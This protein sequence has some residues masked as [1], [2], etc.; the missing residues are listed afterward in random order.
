MKRKI[1]SVFMSLA[2]FFAVFPVTA[3]AAGTKYIVTADTAPVLER[4]SP[5]SQ[6]IFELAKGDYVNVSGED[7]DFMYVTVFSAG[8]SGWVYAPLLSCADASQIDPE[9]IVRISVTQKP[10]RLV[11]TENED[12]FDPA[13]LIVSAEKTDKSVVRLTGYKIYVPD[14]SSPGVK[15]VYISYRSKGAAVSFSAE[16]DIEVKK[17]PLKALT[18]LTLPSKEQTSYIE[19]QPLDLTGLT[20]KAS[21]TDGREDRVF[22]LDEIL[23]DSDFTLTGCHSETHGK[24]LVKGSHT[25]NIYYKYSEISCS[26]TFK[27]REKKLVSFTVSSPPKQLTVYT[28]ELPDLTGMELTAVYDNGET[29]SVSPSECL[30]TC[31]PSKFILGDGNRMTLSYGGKSVSV[32]FTYALLEKTGLRLR[33]PQTLTFILGEPIDLSALEV[34]YVY[35]SGDIQKTERFTRSFIDPV[36]TGAQTVTVTSENFSAAFTIYINPYYQ[37]GDIDGDGKI[38]A[39]DARLALRNSVGLIR[40][41]GE[42]LNG[43]DAD[44]DGKVTAADARLILRAAVGL[45]DFLKDIRN[46]KI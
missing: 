43:A 40:L 26:L 22:T 46:T 4:S 24:M 16:F 6:K 7:G 45:E 13:G 42:Q 9:G 37:R 25:L 41:G 23:A 38:A 19:G 27:A 29:V 21:Y 5:L 12:E 33:L 3:S 34:Y 31:D 44:R 39:A 28:R 2:L 1:F 10:D 14:L 32:D 15:T 36:R 8:I 30:I 20:L 17:V 18:V 11:Y 35:S